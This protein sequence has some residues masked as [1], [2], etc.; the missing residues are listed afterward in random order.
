MAGDADPTSVAESVESEA[1]ANTE[2][3]GVAEAD[4]MSAYAWSEDDSPEEVEPAPLRPFLITS[5]AVGVSLCLVTVAG[6]LGYR[7]VTDEAPTPVAVSA[8]ATTTT[9]P[10]A[11]KAAPPVPPPPPV[12][13]TTV[14]V[15]STVQ[16][17]GQAPGPGVLP[18]AVLA[19]LDQ[20]FIANLQAKGWL[21]TDARILA[22]DAHKLC[23]YLQRGGAIGPATQEY[24]SASGQG[25]D[26]AQQFVSTVVGTYPNCP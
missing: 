9:V 13:V 7:W 5:A 10:P 17:P 8:P 4:T 24:A 26:H 2:L 18:P 20:R 1:A 19:S 23:A 3:A 25:L 21:I 12:T 11:P 16:V 15:Q 22:S 14:V 6:V